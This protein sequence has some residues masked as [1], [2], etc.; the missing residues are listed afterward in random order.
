MIKTKYDSYFDEKFMKAIDDIYDYAKAKYNF[1]ANSI[2]DLYAISYDATNGKTYFVAPIIPFKD[3]IKCYIANDIRKVINKSESIFQYQNYYIDY[4]YACTVNLEGYK[5]KAADECIRFINSIKTSTFIID[6]SEDNNIEPILIAF[7]AAKNNPSISD[8]IERT[9]NW[10]IEVFH[11]SSCYIKFSLF[12][13]V[14]DI[15]RSARYSLLFNRVFDSNNRDKYL[16][17][18]IRDGIISPVKNNTNVLKDKQEIIDKK[19]IKKEEE[20]KMIAPDKEFYNEKKEDSIDKKFEFPFKKG[21]IAIDDNGNVYQ[22]ILTDVTNGLN[23][24]TEYRTMVL[25]CSINLKLVRDNFV[26]NRGDMYVT[27]YYDFIERFKKLNI[28]NE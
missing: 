7:N 17:Q 20:S 25:Y 5:E 14:V 12:K 22:I 18:S 26:I 3:I 15:E 11:G 27:T 10:K 13:Y 19:E 1:S 8:N 9:I 24:V 2:I 28:V 16:P 21:D 6:V 4:F 23:E